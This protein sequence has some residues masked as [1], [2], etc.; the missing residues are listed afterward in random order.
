MAVDSRITPTE[1]SSKAPVS[2]VSPLPR[3]KINNSADSII[4]QTL[5]GISNQMNVFEQ[6][7]QSARQ[8]IVSVVE[9][10]ESHDKVLVKIATDGKQRHK[11]TGSAK[12]GKSAKNN[13]SNMN[14]GE[15]Q[16][17]NS[18]QNLLSTNNSIF[19]QS[20]NNLQVAGQSVAE[21]AVPYLSAAISTASNTASPLLCSTSTSACMDSNPLSSSVPGYQMTATYGIAAGQTG[22]VFQQAPVQYVSNCKCTGSKTVRISETGP[23]LDGKTRG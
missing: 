17:S 16:I 9:K 13:F 3:S 7:A 8:L 14:S 4:L 19:P 20:L 23:R 2:P 18:Q 10:L 11:S 21:N 15:M 1:A 6:D 12:G 22:V 5:Q